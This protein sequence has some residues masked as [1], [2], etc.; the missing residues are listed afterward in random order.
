LKECGVD[1]TRLHILYKAPP[2]EVLEWDDA[3]IVGM[4]RWLAKVLKLSQN[5]SS[6]QEIPTTMT[7]D[8]KEMYRV[9]HQTIK[10]VTEAMS[11]TYAFNT[12]ISDMIKLSNH[13]S[14]SVD[15]ESPVYRHAVQNLVKMM[16]PFAP[17]VS[18]ECWEHVGDDEESVFKQAWPV[19][20]QAALEKDDVNCII[21]V[22]IIIKKKEMRYTY[23]LTIVLY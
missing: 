8:E 12:A 6:T 15:V 17:T 10:Q 5:A 18:E 22:I 20:E 7:K 11:T 14:G 19:W 13:I 1:S 9:T 23:I 21:Q 16:A 3:S 2:S 4:Q